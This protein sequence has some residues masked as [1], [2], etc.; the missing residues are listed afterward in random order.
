M[1]KSTSPVRRLAEMFD[2]KKMEWGALVVMMHKFRKSLEPVQKVLDQ[3][4]ADGKQSATSQFDAEQA[5]RL[6]GADFAALV[7]MV[8][9][10]FTAIE[11][12]A[13][14]LAPGSASAAAQDFAELLEVHRS[15][16]IAVM[17][18]MGFADAVAAQ[19][20]GMVLTVDGKEVT[21]DSLADYLLTKF[22]PA[23][24]AT[25][26]APANGKELLA[27]IVRILGLAPDTD[28]QHA[29]KYLGEM[30]AKVEAIKAI[31]GGDVLEALQL[32]RESVEAD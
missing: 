27:E 20:A 9:R 15:L 17:K 5:Q 2:A 4:V 14:A 1:P 24:P 16:K 31:T 18:Y 30:M 23:A 10:V 26:S 21:A 3:L 11:N 12:P 19:K 25:P 32:A 28:R 8:E 7:A 22:K 13:P 29:L 6:V